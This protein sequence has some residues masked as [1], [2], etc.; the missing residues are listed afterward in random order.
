MNC[1]DAR[2]LLEAKERTPQQEEQLN[3]HLESCEDCRSYS[4]YRL[5]CLTLDDETPLP[6]SFKS[7]WRQSIKEEENM[8]KPVLSPKFKRILSLAAVFVVVIAGTIL[9]RDNTTPSK[10]ADYNYND[11]VMP[12][13][14][15]VSGLGGSKSAPDNS[16]FAVE[17]AAPQS[18]EKSASMDA[19]MRSAGDLASGQA[20]VKAPAKLIRT[21]DM[22]ISTRDFD[23]D[24]QKIIASLK[25]HGGYIESSTINSKTSYRRQ[26]N[27]YLRVPQEK[28][29]KFLEDIGGLGRQLSFSESAEDVSEKYA[30][31]ETR[32]TTQ[33]EKMKRLQQMLSKATSIE[34][35][36]IIENSIADTQYQIDRLSGSLKGMDSRVN[37]S[38]VNISLIEERPAD[39]EQVKE[40]TLGER[41]ASAFKNSLD[42]IKDFLAD[43][44]VFIVSVSPVIIALLVV[45]KIIRR[46][47]KKR[48]NK[49]NEK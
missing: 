44:L 4:T 21:V 22:S 39:I 40:A 16:F 45:I 13:T 33:Q 43:S 15:L 36:I 6:E 25:E 17:E 42:S 11:Y 35:L 32:L 47:I 26:A 37:Y 3:E 48:R 30:D 18:A 31:T 14:G 41:I 12:P 9:T 19:T 7:N 34:E 8:K 2:T 28:L 5:D 27:L 24:Y 38:T 10:T 49:K 20:E 46:A 29:D 23:E 1:N